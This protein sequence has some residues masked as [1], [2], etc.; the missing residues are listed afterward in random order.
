M[1]GQ[2]FILFILLFSTLLF[3]HLFPVVEGVPRGA[4]VIIGGGL[5]E[6]NAA[7]YNRFIQL[8]GGVDRIRIAIIPAA[9]VTP[10]ESGRA[11]IQDFGRYGVAAE[12]IKVFPLAIIDDPITPDTDES[13]WAGNGSKPE[14]A[15]EMRGYSAVFFVGG[16]QERYIRTLKTPDGQDVPLLAAIREVYRGGGVIGGT[17]A[18][19]AIMSDPMICG[20][21]SIDAMVGEAVY[22]DSPCPE[23][24]GVRLTRGLGF[25]NAGLVDQHFIKRGRMGRVLAALFFLPRVDL[26]IGIDE[27]TAAI[28]YGDRNVVEVVGRSGVLLVDVSQVL[29]TARRG[30]VPIKN[31]VLHYLEAGDLYHLDTNRFEIHA[32]RKLIEKGK[33]YYD[34]SPLQTAIFGKDA[35]KDIITAG[36]VDCSVTEAAGIGFTLDKLEN[37]NQSSIGNGV[38]LKFRK[39]K[40]TQ[41]YSGTIDGKETYSALNVYLDIIPVNVGVEP[42]PQLMRGTQR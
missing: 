42:I 4:L 13:L 28:F 12:R 7:V 30:G 18:G 2:R 1:N 9:S 35:V 27:D 19:A 21:D 11:Y 41:G 6:D 26:G 34:S 37:K 31:I 15:E 3:I 38:Q 33:E 5:E 14:L 20:G 36:L 32:G 39:G 10:V 29:P 23:K 8:G 40:E 22:S 24:G 16:D 25:F 17:S